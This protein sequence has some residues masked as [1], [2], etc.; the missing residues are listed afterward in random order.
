MT[1]S[2]TCA[3]TST[4]NVCRAP[5]RAMGRSRSR[6]G[7]RERLFAFD[8]DL[9]AGHRV[10]DDRHFEILGLAALLDDHAFTVVDT[11]AEV[12]RAERCLQG[13]TQQLRDTVLRGF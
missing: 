9:D 11:D 2:R 7:S 5:T 1:C 12:F 6:G 13:V 10:V 8:A 3:C 4:S